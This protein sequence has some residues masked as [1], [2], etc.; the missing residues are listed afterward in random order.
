MNRYQKFP[1]LDHDDHSTIG[2]KSLRELAKQ[3][4]TANVIGLP[5]RDGREHHLKA[6]AGLGGHKA[7]I[8]T[9]KFCCEHQPDLSICAAQTLDAILRS[10]TRLII[11]ILTT[12]Q[13]RIPNDTRR[14]Y[15]LMLMAAQKS[16]GWKAEDQWG[17][18]EGSGTQKPPCER[19]PK[20]T[21]GFWEIDGEKPNKPHSNSNKRGHPDG[22]HRK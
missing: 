12:H 15:Q 7:F 14:W 4:T 21:R 6:S 10:N 9:P 13:T 20:R 22:R 18:I 17:I 2:A 5:L 11:P 1:R 16:P 8:A 19:P 3:A